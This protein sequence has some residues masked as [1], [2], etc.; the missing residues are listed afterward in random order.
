MTAYLMTTPRIPPNAKSLRECYPEPFMVVIASDE[1]E[2][3]RLAD[4]RIDEVARERSNGFRPMRVRGTKA[5]ELTPGS[6]VVNIDGYPYFAVG[7]DGGTILYPV[8]DTR[9]P[10][11]VLAEGNLDGEETDAA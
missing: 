1:D 9:D 5:W 2:A 3:I 4:K 10:L 7:G 11:E 6:R 8:I